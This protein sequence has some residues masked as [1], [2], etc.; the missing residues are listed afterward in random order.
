MLDDFKIEHPA[1]EGAWLAE[2]APS[3]SIPPA[4]HRP[5]S[6]KQERAEIVRVLKQ[7]GKTI[8]DIAELFGAR[9]RVN[10]RVAFRYAHGWS[11]AAV[12]TEWC[13]RWPEDPK[14]FK[15]ISTWE[16][17]P[18]GGHPPSLQTLGRLAQLYECSASQLLADLPDY[19]QN[20][21]IEESA[22]RP[23]D[24]QDFSKIDFGGSA[25]GDDYQRLGPTALGSGRV[26]G[27]GAMQRRQVFGLG[28]L[29]VSSLGGVPTGNDKGFGLV[30]VSHVRYLDSESVRL[31]NL[32]YLHGGGSLWRAAL[33]LSQEGYLMLEQGQYGDDLAEGLQ[34]AIG[35]AQ[36]CAG[37][38]ALDSGRHDIAR[39][40]FNEALSLA[41]QVGDPHLEI[42]ALCNLAFQ[43]NFL[44]MPRQ[45]LRFAEAADRVSK[46]AAPKVRVVLNLRKATALSMMGDEGGSGK[47][48][49]EARR[50]LDRDRD[51]PVPEWCGFVTRAEVDGVDG[52]RLLNVARV[53]E[54]SRVARRAARTL[55]LAIAAHEPRFIRNKALYRVRLAQSQLSLGSVQ[56]HCMFR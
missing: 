43:S 56:G 9:Y 18:D 40:S 46:N 48:I 26:E 3:A 27:Q 29:L 34:Q 41:R 14:T 35:R 8:V 28:A 2:S 45:A 12:A 51:Q 7:R 49:T 36:M 24:S 23:R 11:Q 13:R 20:Q 17:W 6:R 37:W 50:Y 31:R 52:T 39:S 42:H 53:K 33:S 16:V 5:Q 4:A 25:E 54:D 22:N 15:A 10:A 38:L 1:S 30:G 44:E 21:G 55:E 32:C 19:G 47:A